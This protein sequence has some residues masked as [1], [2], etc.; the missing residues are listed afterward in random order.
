MD[1][2]ETQKKPK[3]TPKKTVKKTEKKEVKK[4][5]KIKCE[6]CGKKVDASLKKCPHCCAYLREEDRPVVEKKVEEVKPEPVVTPQPQRVVNNVA[7]KKSNNALL[8]SLLGGG[9]ALVLITIIVLGIFIIPRIFVKPDTYLARGDY[10]KAYKVAKNDEAKDKVLIENIIAY[11]AKEIQSVLK[12]PSSFVLKNVYY[13]GTNEFVFEV[14]AKNSYGANVTNY[15]DYRYNSTKGRFNLFVYLPTL[16]NDTLYST[17]TA[18]KKLEKA[19]KNAVRTTV[20][21]MIAD[22]SMRQDEKLIKRINT[23][24]EKDKL[25]DVELLNEVTR[26]YDRNKKVETSSNTN[27]M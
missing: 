19:I 10:E 3:T 7:P 27:N 18:D 20:K 14:V 13:N 24:F 1:K 11:N 16:N 6:Y 23:L 8:F 26:I 15:Y 2:K 9:L 12:D 5:E 22:E 21:K 17:D 4:V 25:K